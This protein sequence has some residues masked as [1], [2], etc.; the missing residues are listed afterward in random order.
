M[1]QMPC[2]WVSTD[3]Y[4]L[5]LVLQ[6]KEGDRIQCSIPHESVSNFESLIQENSIYSM[7]N[8]I[9]KVVRGGLRVTSHKYKLG[10]YVKT[11]VRRLPSNE[12]P[13]SPFH[14]TPFPVIEAMCSLNN[15]FLID[16]MGQVVGREDPEDIITKTGQS[17]K[18][19]QLYL[20]DG[21][22]NKMKCTLFGDFVDQAL[23]YLE[24]LVIVTQLFKPHVFLS[25][26]NVQASLYASHV[27]FNPS[28]PAVVE[29]R[30]RLLTLGEEFTQPISHVKSQ[31]QRS[32]TDEISS[33][34]FP[35][36][37]VEEVLNMTEPCSCWILASIVSIEGGRDGWFYASCKGCFKKVIPKNDVYHCGE[38]GQHGTKPPIKYRLKV[39]VND[40]TG[41]L[42]LLLWNSEG[43]MIVGKS[44]A[45]VRAAGVSVEANN[46]E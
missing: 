36:R 46:L 26:V 37:T 24:P 32:V 11:S 3:A 43:S 2:Q 31:G 29:F 16:C 38:C 9:V 23:R 1:Y 27:L 33:G 21:E 7:C 22:K 14:F 13:F 18:R 30:D 34:E 25:D 39:I 10:F 6:D 28:L 20:E 12:F 19:L 17:S 4:T 44:A 15:I 8:F 35:L 45:E 5:E 42:N 40:F 41:C